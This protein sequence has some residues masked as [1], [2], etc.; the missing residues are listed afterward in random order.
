MHESLGYG[1]AGLLMVF[2]GRRLFWLFVACVGFLFGLY[3]A[4]TVF[5]TAESWVFLTCALIGGIAGALTAVFLQKAAVGVAGFLA[6]GWLVKDFVVYVFETS[7]EIGW[8][9][10]FVGGLLGALLI[11]V[12]FEWALIVLTSVLGA[13]WIAQIQFFSAAVQP[14]VVVGMAGLGILVQAKQRL[15]RRQ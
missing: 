3:L 12:M 8:I 9:S 5:A 14:I 2:F 15:R 1:I 13:A 11:A 7:P 4:E 6:G 10:F